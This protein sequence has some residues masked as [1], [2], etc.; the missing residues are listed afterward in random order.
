MKPYKFGPIT[1]MPHHNLAYVGRALITASNKNYF[2]HPEASNALVI[3]IGKR[4][5]I[6]WQ[7]GLKDV[8]R[9]GKD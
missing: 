4:I 2:N 5:T 7:K 6:V 1:V 3:A 8:P 9:T